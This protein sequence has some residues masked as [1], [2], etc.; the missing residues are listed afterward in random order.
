MEKKDK[1]QFENFEKL[2]GLTKDSRYFFACKVVRDGE[3]GVEIMTSA[4]SLMIVGIL[5]HILDKYPHESAACL[6]GRVKSD[7]E[8][9]AMQFCTSANEKPI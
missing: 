3:D 7:M 8:K 9:M 1:L 2:N 6:M 4:D 5:S